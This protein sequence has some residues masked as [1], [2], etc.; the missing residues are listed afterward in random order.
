MRAAAVTVLLL[1]TA[2]LAGAPAAPPPP[3]PLPATAESL[4][5]LLEGQPWRTVSLDEL[6]G[7]PQV[8]FVDPTRQERRGPLLVELLKSL[9]IAGAGRLVVTGSEPG[10]VELPWARVADAQEQLA[11][12]FMPGE[13]PMLVGKTGGASDRARRVHGVRSI[14]V[15]GARMGT[16]PAPDKAAGSGTGHGT[17]GAGPAAPAPGGVDAPPETIQ[18]VA[19]DGTA[20]PFRVEGIRTA[21]TGTTW[22]D[23]QAFSF[24][25]L[26]AVLAAAGFTGVQ[27]VRVVG[28][29]ESLELRAGASDVP[30]PKDYG[31]I[32]N[33]RGFLV[34]TRFQKPGGPPRADRGP[35]VRRF[36]RIEVLR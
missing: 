33:R 18:I 34:L 14:D 8:S 21:A 30:D 24:T 3:T 35:E 25:P 12:A 26:L 7:L 28:D 20:R 19:P 29:G 15:Q 27:G 11:L 13:R 31:V 1:I 32:F 23:E 17:P 9:G 2:G 5:V 36:D 10:P 6:R 16:G 4:S 22:R